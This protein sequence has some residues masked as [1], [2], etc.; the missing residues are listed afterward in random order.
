VTTYSQDD[1]VGYLG[2][3]YISNQDANTNH[4]PTDTA[5]W[6]LW[7]EKG[8][9]GEQGIQGVQ[10][11]Q[12]EQGPNM[13]IAMGNIGSDGTINVGYHVTSCSYN[14]EFGY[15]DIDLLDISY[16]SV[17]YVTVVTPVL[18]ATSVRSATSWAVGGNLGVVLYNSAGDGVQAGFSFM[19]LDATP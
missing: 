9:T 14:S 4:L 8:D 13:I 18:S 15:Y 19:V 3:S 6:N 10:G 16:D 12:G 17:S 1:A 11:I 7:V 2:S 5:W